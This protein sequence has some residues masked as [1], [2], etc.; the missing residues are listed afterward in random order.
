MAAR[1]QTK[2]YRALL[3]E[4]GKHLNGGAPIQPEQIEMVYWYTEFPSE[5]ANFRYD[6]AQHKRDWDNLV[7][8]VSE[9]SAKQ[10]YPMT[11][12]EKKCAYCLYRSY[13]ERGTRAGEGEE[14]ETE[15]ADAEITLEQIQE[16]EF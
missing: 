6:N 11:D 1:L 5:P 16:I 14:P 9:I 15:L 3:A 10:S 7:K 2:V 13:C 4:A 8:L 12:D